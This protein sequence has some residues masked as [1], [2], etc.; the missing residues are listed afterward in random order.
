MK[1]FSDNIIASVCDL[2]Q[3]F[4]CVSA[5]PSVKLA[6][7]QVSLMQTWAKAPI[8]IVFRSVHVTTFAL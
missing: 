3:V 5:Y 7:Q 2:E 6:G 1:E 4:Q 8:P